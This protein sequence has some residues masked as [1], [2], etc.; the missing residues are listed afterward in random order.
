MERERK[1]TAPCCLL[2]LLHPTSCHFTCSPLSWGRPPTIILP[3]GQFL[4]HL[5]ASL[6]IGACSTFLIMVL[7]PSLPL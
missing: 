4:I 1:E 2:L 5:P 7:P 6:P 3:P